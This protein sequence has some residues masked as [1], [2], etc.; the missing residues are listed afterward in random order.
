[1]PNRSSPGFNHPPST[2]WN[3]RGGRWSSVERMC[4]ERLIKFCPFTLM[5]V[6]KINNNDGFKAPSQQRWA[7]ILFYKVILLSI[8]FNTSSSAASQILLCRRMLSLNPC[9]L[10]HHL[11]I[12]SISSSLHLNNIVLV[13]KRMNYLEKRLKL[14]IFSWF[15]QDRWSHKF[16]VFWI[17]LLQI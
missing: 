10:Q 13:K 1:M 7:L 5:R 4:A 14:S 16:T 8:L 12:I 3:M 17:T 11:K 15:S 2:Q 6:C 9:M